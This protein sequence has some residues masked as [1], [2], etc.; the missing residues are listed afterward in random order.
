MK[1]LR[2]ILWTIFGL[3]AMVLAIVLTLYSPWGGNA[4]AKIVSAV[5]SDSTMT[6]HIG[7]LDIDWP[8]RVHAGDV[9][10]SMADGLRLRADML[11]ADLSINDLLRLNLSMSRATIDRLNL[12]MGAEDSLMYMRLH[13]EKADLRSASV[14]LSDL[15]IAVDSALLCGGDLALQLNPD[16]AAVAPPK[17]EP[18]EPSTMLL[19]VNHLAIDRFHYQMRMLPT[20]DSLAVTMNLADAADIAVNL[21]EQ[22]INVRRFDVDGADI[23][24]IAPDSATVAATPPAR[25]DTIAPDTAPWTIT[26]GSAIFD[27]ARA[28]YTT[29]GISPAD[30]LDFGYIDVDSMQLAV[31]DFYNQAAQVKVPLKLRGIERCGI[32]LTASGRLDIDERG[33]RLSDFNIQTDQQTAL[34]FSA[35]MGL[36]DLAA[37]PTLPLRL[38]LDGQAAT[39]DLSLM[40]PDFNPYLSALPS[41]L[42]LT[43]A[44]SGTSGR[45]NIGR[46]RFAAP[47][48]LTLNGSGLLTNAFRPDRLGGNVSLDGQLANVN[49]LMASMIGESSVY[50]PATT[51]T[52]DA[53]FSPTDIGASLRALSGG[54]RL[55]FDGELAAG[56]EYF[57]ALTAENFPLHSFLP[58]MDLGSLTATLTADGQGFDIADPA[59]A[60]Q[61]NFA[62]AQAYFNGY[63]YAGISGELSA[64][65]GIAVADI[66]ST[67]S[68]AQFALHANGNLAGD[69]YRWQA[70]LDAPFFDLLDLHF[71]DVETTAAADLAAEMVYTPERNDL[72]AHLQLNSL[73]YTTPISA[74]RLSG[75]GTHL[76]ANDSLTTIAISNRDLQADGV[77]HASLQQL[78][79]V[80]DTLLAEFD[81]QFATRIINIDRVFSPLPKAQF[82][83]S[84]GSNNF[85][86]DIA[87]GNRAS[88]HSLD[89]HALNDESFYLN[90]E[91][92]G[93]RNDEMR[94]DTTRLEINQFGPRLIYQLNIGN[95]PGTFDQWANV[96]ID[97][98]IFENSAAFHMQQHDITGEQG[99][100]VGAAIA[101]LDSV[102]TMSLEPLDPTIA[103]KPWTVNDDNYISWNFNTSALDANLHLNSATSAVDV[104][105]DAGDLNLNLHDIRIEE[106]VSLNPFAP[107]MRGSL[108]ADMKISHRPGSLSGSGD[109]A[110]TDFYYNRQ[111]VGDVATHLTLATDTLRQLQADL[112]M[113]VDGV[114]TVTL[115]GVLSDSTSA[116]PLNLDMRMIHLPLASLNPFMPE[117]TAS[118]K[119]YLNGTIDVSGRGLDPRFNGWL[120]FDSAAVRVAIIG[121]EYPISDVRVP[122]DSNIVRFNSFGIYGVNN[123]AMTLNG[124]VDLRSMAKP[125][126]DLTLSAKNFQACNTSRAPR[127]AD[128]YGKAFISTN[129][130]V[131]GNSDFIDINSRFDILSGTNVT[132]IMSDASQVIAAQSM[133]EL[134]EFVTFADTTATTMAEDENSMAMRLLAQLN[135]NNGT[136]ISVDLSPDGKDR[137]RMQCNGNFDFQWPAFADPRLTGRLNIT[138]GFARYSPPLLG[139][140]SFDF[141]DGS[142]IAFTGDMLNPTLA[143]S[144]TDRVKAN[145]KSNGAAPRS[146]NFDVGL[147]VGGTL[148]AMDVKF[149]LSTI[150]DISIANE[151]QSMSAEQRANQAMNMLLYGVYTGASS[152]TDGGSISG[153]ALYSFLTSQIN[154]WAANTIQGVDLSFGIDQTNNEQGVSSMSYSYQ[155]SKS[156]FNDRFKIVVGGNYA[157]DASADENFSQNL[158]K[159]ISFEYYLNPARTMMARLFRH[160]G[161]ESI[162]EGEITKTGVG[163]VYRRS[164][165]SLRQLFG[166]RPKKADRIDNQST[167]SASSNGTQQ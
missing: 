119:G 143:L 30:G 78:S 65:D 18:S 156:L 17:P 26:L 93:F 4:T 117:H 28:L 80:A 37:D 161:Y 149:D 7:K 139:E 124:T 68:N 114:E 2:V 62:I 57:A 50:I 164:L 90:S 162:L 99:Y 39:A 127:Y 103:Y 82:D 29:R 107:P 71:A 113:K 92:L 75:I 105:T 110:L 22:S 70:A 41:R 101:L 152:S 167:E 89:L 148:S 81:R 59:M 38:N 58:G 53:D 102:L 16:T 118:L 42:D 141:N 56:D 6:I 100:D 140:K 98:Y 10:L 97:G 47:S 34:T 125:S 84:A 106:W 87:A 163:F 5:V 25:V 145:V 67:N 11:D 43:T 69:T 109:F 14:R 46:L 64:A 9:N 155:V 60:L 31:N 138:G 123:E 79:V 19:S 21:G 52:L 142:Y 15:H 12:D 33:L 121:T 146:I 88:F 135:I 134:V 44:V 147:N 166:L 150:D 159:D 112:A 61:A 158:I 165:T 104:F 129:T 108:S 27:H 95:R 122:L 160:T 8:L 1:W 36:G 154:S 120:Q 94:I 32:A 72:A 157:T 144:A 3:I 20:I 85:I 136:T 76:Q 40:F 115:R 74:I 35:M 83:L 126:L 130:T 51:F 91:I 131:R 23:A 13:A 48:M 63:D 55:D 153:N 73:R 54:G 111:R 128:I 77:V 24:Y 96:D 137:V 66:N 116:S 151:L 49:P 86:A 132:Y 133:D 45:L